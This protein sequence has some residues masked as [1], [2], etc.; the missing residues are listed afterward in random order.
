MHDLHFA[1]LKKDI[2]KMFV[3]KAKRVGKESR[4][5]RVDQRDQHARS[6]TVRENVLP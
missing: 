3:I 6:D 4:A 1:L 5:V 2:F